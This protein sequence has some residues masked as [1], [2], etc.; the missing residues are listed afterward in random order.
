MLSERLGRGLAE[1]DGRL[2]V[3]LDPHPGLVPAR[4]G[5]GAR[6]VGRFLRWVIRETRP[7]ACAF[8]PNAAF[9]EA[10]GPRGLAVL[11][12]TAAAVHAADRPV[13]LDAKR[14]DIAT[15][16]A[17]YAKA[18]VDVVGADAITV[19]PYMGDEAVRPFLDRGLFAFLLTLPTN[20]SA[21]EIA[22]YGAPPVCVRV[23]QLADRLAA[24]YP[25]QV[26]LIV[27]ATQPAWVSAVHAAAPELRWLVPGVGAQ[28][29]DVQAFLD[30]AAQH[31]AIIVNA[32]RAILGSA[33][34]R[35]AAARL[36]EQLGGQGR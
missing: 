3:G 2:C 24:E 27:G 10:L 5:R 25:D 15:T 21:A 28:G 30:A 1:S 19:V 13:I 11:R 22:C 18:T 4:F 34:P 26:G 12:D 7:H 6:G 23:A 9:F 14:G 31:A 29:A 17:A 16:A 20:R 36:K 35:A 33:D 32:S 8:K